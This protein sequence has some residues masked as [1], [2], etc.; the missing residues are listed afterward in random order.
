M[1]ITRSSHGAIRVIWIILIEE[2]GRER[3]YLLIRESGRNVRA[4][5]LILLV[6]KYRMKEK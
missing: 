5:K 2:S 6:R 3:R 4:F 1:R